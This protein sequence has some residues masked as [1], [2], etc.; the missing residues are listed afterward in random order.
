MGHDYLK[1]IIF[2]PKTMVTAWVPCGTQLQKSSPAFTMMFHGSIVKT[3]ELM[4]LLE[5]SIVITM[6][7]W[8]PPEWNTKDNE[9][10]LNSFSGYI[11]QELQKAY[12]FHP[13]ESSWMLPDRVPTMAHAPFRIPNTH[14]PENNMATSYRT[15]TCIESEVEHVNFEKNGQ[16]SLRFLESSVTA[17]V[18]NRWIHR[19]R[20]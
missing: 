8:L 12:L 5:A 17:L 15:L 19:S 16:P 2:Y 9:E 14:D 7:T 10:L 20:F 1:L 3:I 4:S 13:F 6:S 11:W 18:S